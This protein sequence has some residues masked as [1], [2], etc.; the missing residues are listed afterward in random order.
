MRT[1]FQPADR[2]TRTVVHG[3][4]EYVIDMVARLN[5]LISGPNSGHSGTYRGGGSGSMSNH[6]SGPMPAIQNFRARGALRP[7]GDHTGYRS[8]GS[9]ALPG[10]QPPSG[11]ATPL[12]NLFLQGPTR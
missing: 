12:R 5:S 10:S 3:A 7:P 9:Q 8:N 1:V 11:I 6:F 4:S 2:E